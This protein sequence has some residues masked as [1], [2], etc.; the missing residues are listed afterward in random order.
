MLD[1]VQ[2]GRTKIRY[3]YE[4]KERKTLAIH[5]HP[6]LSVSVDVPGG[7]HVNIIRDKVKK[8]GSWI[9]KTWREFE[10]YLPKQPARKYINGE[11]H[12]YLGRQYRLKARKGK[13]DTVKC[14]RGYFQVTC[15]QKPTPLKVK[16]LLDNWYQE[17][18][19]QVFRQ[20]YNVCCGKLS[21]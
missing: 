6:N 5:V 8:R 16:K 19:N 2:W 11:S 10:L 9:R 14:Y 17:K 18:A 1:E 4:F 21:S 3:S 7:T 13:A 12:R 20:R 15:E